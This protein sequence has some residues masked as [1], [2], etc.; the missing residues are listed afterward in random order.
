M[1][2]ENHYLSRSNLAKEL[3]EMPE[4]FR[5]KRAYMALSVNWKKLAD[6]SAKATTL[7]R[8]HSR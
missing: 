5:R 6:I 1:Y 3:S 8:A 7:P 4:N 2:S